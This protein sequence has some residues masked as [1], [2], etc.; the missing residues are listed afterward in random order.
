M[1]YSSKATVL[2]IEH[3][4]KYYKKN[5][6]VKDISLSVKKGEIFGFLG[7]NGAGKSTTIRCLLGLIKPSGGQMTLFGGRYGSLTESLHHIGY[8]PSEAMFYP[9]MKVKD[10][11]AFAAKVRK[12]DC[13]QEAKRLSELL[14]VPSDKKIEELSLGNRKKVSIVCALQ[15]QPDLIILDE[16]T[17]GLDPLMQERFFKLIKEA[18]SKGATC[19]LSSHVLSEI[20][21]YCDRVA[22]LKNG[23]IVTVDAIHHLTHSMLRK[24]SVWK[25]GKLKTFNYSGSMKDL[26]KQLEEMNPDDL[27]IEEP[28][29]ESLFLHYYEEKDNDHTIS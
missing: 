17:S 29:L 8:M 3:L 19:F 11:I 12:K 1:E 5:I 16:P 21:N 14:E 9:T 27:L 26:L 13:S 7:S 10:V 23:E 25:D 24:V 2:E 4:Q 18:C 20:K 28:S 15:H 22:I 6:G